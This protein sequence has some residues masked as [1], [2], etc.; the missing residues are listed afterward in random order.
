MEN[1]IVPRFYEFDS[2]RLDG[3]K[4]VLL[5]AGAPVALT[6]RALDL[7]FALVERRGQVVEKDELLTLLWPDSVVEENNLTVNVSALRKALGAGPG[8]RRYIV[9]VPGRGYRFVADVAE[10]VEEDSALLPA[11][12]STLVVEESKVR[13]VIEEEILDG[14]VRGGETGRLRD[15][16]KLKLPGSAL[17]ARPVAPSP[18]RPVVFLAL[19][20][21]LLAGGIYWRSKSQSAVHLAEGPP[22]AIKTLAVLPFKPLVAEGRDDYLQMGMADVLITRLSR[23]RQMVVRPL[24]ASRK[25]TALEQDALAAGR[26]LKVD[27]VLDGHIQRA[28]ERVR[29][30]VRLVNVNDGATLWA[31]TLDEKDA[32]LFTVEDR[33]SEKLVAAF[34]LNLSPAERQLL[35][36]RYTANGEAYQA[37]LRGRYFWSKWTK[38][39]LEKATEAFEQALKADPD[40]AP[41]HAG[42]ADAW[43]LL[44][45]LGFLPPREAFPK[46]EAAALRALQLD[47][48]LGEAHLS[49]AKT[50]LF[51]AWDWPA[52]EREIGRALELSPNFADTHGL[53]GAYLLAMG[54]LDEALVARRRAQELDPTSPL[55]TT[56]VGW[57]YF[58]QRRYDQAITWYRKAFE[59][60]PT[61]A[62]AH[63]DLSNALFLKG[64]AE[65]ALAEVLKFRALTGESQAHLTALQQAFA[66]EGKLGYWR[67]ELELAEERARQGA[68]LGA[69]RMARI[70]AE[71]GDHDQSFVWLNRAYEERA[72][73]LAFLKTVPLFGNLHTDPRFAELLRR[74]GHT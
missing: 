17:A 40:Y 21:L 63:D 26:E 8:E 54:R 7:L 52:C 67:K 56:A 62:L 15:G 2:F 72:S 36:R 31:E 64:E 37:Y 58:Y 33:L 35:T 24:S 68:P 30:T 65:Q 29:V 13:L 12:A 16:E 19:L 61:F 47:D 28:G 43:N 55:F 6:P 70:N 57:A 23:L 42:V 74:I 51:Y 38:A 18:T 69:W 5:R 32:D 10:I 44:G 11:A 34:A 59:L 9:T 49:L 53:N 1:K 4:R 50:K 27:A 41:A 45:Y 14:E 60:D 25:Y 66:A 71:L 73:M 22:S 3:R 48:T 39:S 46:S 20:G